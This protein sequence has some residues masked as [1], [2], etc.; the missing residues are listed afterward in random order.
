MHYPIDGKTKKP[1][2]VPEEKKADEESKKE[3]A[4]IAIEKAK[5][6]EAK[7]AEDGRRIKIKTRK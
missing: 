1:Y 2:N 3:A 7:A 6:I 5:P 4:D